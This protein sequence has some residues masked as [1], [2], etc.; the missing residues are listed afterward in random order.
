MKG[1]REWLVTVGILLLAGSLLRAVSHGE[2]PP[3]HRSLATFPWQIGV[4]TGAERS[5]GPAVLQVLQVDDYLFRQ[6]QQG[7]QGVPIGVYVG[8]Y[9]SMRQGATY[10]SPRHCLPGSGWSFLTT[11]TAQLHIGAGHAQTMTVNQFV[12][13]KG[14]DKQLVLY[15][16]Q[17]RG[18]V[19]VSEYWAKLYMVLDAI[20]R[21]R[22]DGAFVR[23]T[24]PI[25][26]QAEDMAYQQGV[27]FATQLLPVLQTYL[28]N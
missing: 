9:R 22:T 8:Y 12:I 27:A 1:R 26:P 10:H 2:Q 15:W 25:L 13:Q 20:T 6:Y 14:L 5:L 3:P 16:Y 17:D 23:I 7:R 24:V 18:R 4:W 28:P 11:G 19:I 21:Q